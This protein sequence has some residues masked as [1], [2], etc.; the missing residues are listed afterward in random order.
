[1]PPPPIAITG[2]HRSGTSMVTRGLHQSGLVLLGDG[3]RLIEPADDNPE[4]FWENKRIVACNDEL[5]E[6]AGGS[7]DN[8]PEL[9][10]Q[11]VDDPRFEAVGERAIEAL[12]GLRDH[13]HWGFKDPRTCLTAGYWIDLEPELR[14]VLCVR[15]PLEV[16][17]SLRR[18]NQNS[19]SLGLALWERY[20]EAALA[21]MPA[22]RLLVTHYDTW[23]HDPQGELDR[24]CTFTGLDRAEVSV[25]RDLRHHTIGVSLT[26]AGVSD[27]VV[28]LYRTLCGEAGDPQPPSPPADAGRV[29]RLILDGTV[30]ARHAEQRQEAIDQLHERETELR[31]EL[32][33]LRHE[34]RSA[35]SQLRARL[36][37]LEAELTATRRVAVTR[38]KLRG[39]LAP[40]IDA[41]AITRDQLAGLDQVVR[42]TAGRV[43][44]AVANTRP[45]PLARLW[46]RS[47][48]RV[49]RG[50]RRYV[51]RP[52]RV[53]AQRGRRAA[54]PQAKSAA[55][56]LPPTTQ[57]ALRRGR[58][59]VHRTRRQSTDAPPPAAPPTHDDAPVDDRWRAH[60]ADM[61]AA[62]IGDQR[63]LVLDIDALT[64]EPATF[65]A[66]A[67][68]GLGA[69]A[70]LE[71]RRFAG[72]R[73]LAVAEGSRSWLHDRPELRDHLLGR[74]RVVIDQ[75]DAGVVFDLAAPHHEATVTLRG[76]ITRLAGGRDTR[77]AV[78]DWTGL[79]I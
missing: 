14:F 74:Y 28:E 64:D 77:P 7:W 61:L 49:Y 75:P 20:Y 33:H 60:F 48:R 37:S 16:A 68:D 70:E 19:Y 18:R 13:D 56:R 12:A 63:H 8:P 5:L 66:H 17:L 69:I 4:G 29:R 58:R 44:V 35:E 30:A 57:T 25:R 79:D 41:A 23:F 2:M 51:F 71:A 78:L 73:L 45:S 65:P 54:L 59:L 52:T 38:N 22:D 6:A 24:L 40:L 21:T 39:E 46:K 72:A 67:S 9:L 10:P 3:D 26:D 47:T 42:D 32:Q 53:A 15:H 55:R 36:Q 31:A 50:G 34:A 62:T 76:E 43:E 27:R 11:A 1:M